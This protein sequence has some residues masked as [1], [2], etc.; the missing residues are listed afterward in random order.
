MDSPGNED[1]PNAGNE[2]GPRRGPDRSANRGKAALFPR[3]LAVSRLS[4]RS[5]SRGRRVE[6]FAGKRVGE[7]RIVF[8]AG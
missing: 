2:D 1:R 5:H 8:E 6:A 7:P 4:A 3:V